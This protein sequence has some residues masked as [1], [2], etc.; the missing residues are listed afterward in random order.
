MRDVFTELEAER[1]L[2][3]NSASHSNAL[4]ENPFDAVEAPAEDHADQS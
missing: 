4:V 1:A 2:P 3:H